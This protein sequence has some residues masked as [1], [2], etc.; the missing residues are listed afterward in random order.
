VRIFQGA[1][2]DQTWNAVI[3]VFGEQNWPISELE[4]AS[5]IVITDWLRSS[6]DWTDCGSFKGGNT[7]YR[8]S[9]LQL[10]FNVVVREADGGAS[11][12]VNTIHQGQAAQL[13]MGAWNSADATCLSTGLTEALVLSEVA[14]ALA[15]I[16]EQN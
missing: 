1:S 2:F 15:G 11:V 16:L 5:G 3:D 13:W 6:E 4:K 10:R 9:G 12:R 7:Q 8:I 14:D